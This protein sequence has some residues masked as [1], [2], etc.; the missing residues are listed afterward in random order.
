M[1]PRAPTQLPERLSDRELGV[2]KQALAVGRGDRDQRRRDADDAGPA[3]EVDLARLRDG[4][5]GRRGVGARGRVRVHAFHADGL[6][7]ERAAERIVNG[8]SG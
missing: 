8:I 7:E 3:H 6:S 2:Q 4:V 1:K 5:V